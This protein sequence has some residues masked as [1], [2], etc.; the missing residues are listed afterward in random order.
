MGDYE[1]D[2]DKVVWAEQQLNRGDSRDNR[3][4]PGNGSSLAKKPLFK[5]LFQHRRYKG[6][7]DNEVKLDPMIMG[8]A[9]AAE[10]TNDDF[11]SLLGTKRTSLDV[12]D[13]E[14]TDN[15]S[16]SP[17]S[18]LQAEQTSGK[19]PSTF[20]TH[21]LNAT[22]STPTTPTPTPTQLLTPSTP[23]TPTPTPT[24]LLTPSTPTTPTP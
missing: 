13:F 6:D 15:G 14:D 23:T 9:P 8:A 24:Q 22:P 7:L 3:A 20:K 1:S 16:Y 21:T 18:F 17:G 10:D 19:R 5:P 4:N 2:E 12:G 11:L